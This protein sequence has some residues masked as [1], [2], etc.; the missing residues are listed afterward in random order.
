[1]SLL[2]QYRAA[3][4]VFEGAVR[5]CPDELW[6]ASMWKVLTTDPWVWPKPGVQPIPERTEES[7]QI[8]AAVWP[9]AAHCAFFLDF[10]LSGPHIEGY[11]P[12]SPFE[13][14]LDEKWEADGCVEL[15]PRRFTKAELLDYIAYGR[16]KAE[17]IIPALTDDDMKLLIPEGHPWAGQTYDA[18]L[19]VN[20]NH[21]KEHG[22]QMATFISG[23]DL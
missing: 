11:R 10:Y 17:R 20:L 18:L 23:V 4:D 7:I 3:I 2:E 19:R 14:V 1:M 12:P 13:G 22:G 9:V 15:P 16:E 21:V 5:D 6:D 8:Y